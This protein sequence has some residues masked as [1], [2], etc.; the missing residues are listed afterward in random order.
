MDEPFNRESWNQRRRKS[1]GQAAGR[2]IS[3]DLLL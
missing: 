2:P 1:D 3:D